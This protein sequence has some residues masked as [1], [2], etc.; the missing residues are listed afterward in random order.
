MSHTTTREILDRRTLDLSR[1][2]PVIPGHTYALRPGS[3]TYGRPWL[4]VSRDDTTGGIRTVSL[5][6]ETKREAGHALDAMYDAALLASPRDCRD[7]RSTSC[8]DDTVAVSRGNV[9]PFIFC[10]RHASTL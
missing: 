6:G 10:G 9:R 3:R 5:L 7:A 1:I 4:L 8:S 2:L